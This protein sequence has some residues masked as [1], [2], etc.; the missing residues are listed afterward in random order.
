MGR[1]V[2]YSGDSSL[3]GSY[4]TAVQ[5]T[6]T[7][8]LADVPPTG[9]LCT[10]GPETA[11]KFVAAGYAVQTKSLNAEST[12]Y[13]VVDAELVRLRASSATPGARFDPYTGEPLVLS[14]RPP[15][16]RG[17]NR[18]LVTGGGWCGGR[19]AGRLAR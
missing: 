4:V 8:G 13:P 10:S 12:R 6:P 7:I 3:M 16:R 11:I 18:P 14:D 15:S 5:L 17:S 19:L 9:G 1:G 2:P